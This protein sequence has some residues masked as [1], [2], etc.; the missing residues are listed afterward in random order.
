VARTKEFDPDAA[1][2]AALEL[3]W[4]RGYEATALGDLESATGVSRSS[5]YL[6]FGSKRALFEAA[7]E[8]YEKSWIEPL[9][10][11][12][13]AQG[14][15]L[16][17]AA[18]YFTTLSALFGGSWGQ[19]GC[20]MVNAIA[21]L[22]GIDDGFAG[23]ASRFMARY[24]AAFSNALSL[25]AASGDIQRAAVSRRAKLLTASAIGA[26]VVVRADPATA[27]AYCQ[28]ISSEIRSWA[29]PGIPR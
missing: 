1:L 4:E 19:R 25:A 17:E 2:Q 6:L 13:E 8:D 10:V 28:G 15:G 21:E 5:L 7:L 27:A 12:L 16:A 9:L 18:G 20:M 11:P 22:S 29:R 3:F 23:F 14:A 24:R 26:W